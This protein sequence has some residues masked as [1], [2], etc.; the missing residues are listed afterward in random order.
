MQ[1]KIVVYDAYRVA[2][3]ELAPSRE[4]G[5]G[6][7]FSVIVSKWAS[8]ERLQVSV[9]RSSRVAAM[10]RGL[11]CGALSRQTELIINLLAMEL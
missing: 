10:L 11:R 3:A 9:L 6:L 7:E 2:L 8:D 4:G 1:T 5:G